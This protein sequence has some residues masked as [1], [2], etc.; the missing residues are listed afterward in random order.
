[1]KH[2]NYIQRLTTTNTRSV[3]ALHAKPIVR[4]FSLFLLETHPA[5]FL[6]DARRLFLPLH[7]NLRLSLI[8]DPQIYYDENFI[9]IER[10]AHRV[11]F[12]PGQDNG[13]LSQM[14]DL[15]F[16]GRGLR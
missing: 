3:T 16:R 1:M 9:V 11:E 6:F 15:L 2:R 4:S 13:V 7:N 14:N 8:H 5:G 10:E 12:I